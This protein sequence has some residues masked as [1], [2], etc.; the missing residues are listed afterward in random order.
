MLYR[1]A[2]SSGDENGRIGAPGYGSRASIPVPGPALA[3]D[4]FEP[5]LYNYVNSKG[6][7]MEWGYL[8]RL[9]PGGKT[10]ATTP[11]ERPSSLRHTLV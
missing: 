7:V 1:N 6:I 3:I 8:S 9:K 4:F 10:A 2:T 11:D 5:N